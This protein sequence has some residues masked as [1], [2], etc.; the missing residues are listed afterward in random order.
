LSQRH[1]ATSNALARL[2]IPP[3]YV[4]WVPD[5]EKLYEI[6]AFNLRPNQLEV[7]TKEQ[8]T[9]REAIAK[10]VKNG[11]KYVMKYLRDEVEEPDD[12]DLFL[13][14]AQD[15]VHEAEMLAALSHP[16]IVNLH[17]IIASRHDAFLGGASAFFLILERL[18][19]TLAD[20]I[21][22]WAK[23]KNS[24]NPP[25]S[26]KSLSSSSSRAVAIDKVTTSADKGGSLDNR[27][28][29]AASLAGAVEYLHSQGVIFRDLKPDNVG[30]DEQGIVKLFDFGLSRC[31]PQYSNAYGEV[32]EMTGAGTP[33]YTP[34]EVIFNE[35]YNLKADVYSFSVILW[36]LVCLQQ[37]FAK[38]KRRNEFYRAISR[39]ETLGIN[40]RW[41]Q[42]IQDTIRQV[43]QEI[44]QQDQQ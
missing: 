1:C 8:V 36:E 7:Y 4:R 17:G 33:R 40:R 23:E 14:A 38:F 22:I 25:R 18:E 35:P 15:I 5:R 26:F 6:M 2:P 30:F 32:Y 29:A 21:E 24:F 34:P 19:S 41:P 42:Q 43:S 12:E 37:P 10:S 31:M 28:R 11:A 20:T 3:T 39:G 13:D 9:K 44:L 27:L 16:N